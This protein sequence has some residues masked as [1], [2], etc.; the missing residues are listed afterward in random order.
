MTVT[1][2]AEPLP[3]ETKHLLRT[4]RNLLWAVML[5]LFIVFVFLMAL[6]IQIGQ[7]NDVLNTID[8]QVT[9]LQESQDQVQASVEDAQAFVTEM[10]E[11][12]PEEADRNAAVTEAVQQVPAI[13]SIL[14]EAFPE[15]TACQAP[16]TGP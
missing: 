10:R 5:A 11:V 14:C 16:P 7:R 8:A 4:V 13:R 9:D 15:A 3:E 2:R 6:Q 1:G 12:T